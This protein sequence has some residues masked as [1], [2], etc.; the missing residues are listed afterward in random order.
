MKRNKWLYAALLLWAALI[1]LC[2]R[3][4]ETLFDDIVRCAPRGS[5]LAAGVIVALFA[6]KSV[7]VVLYSGVLY[8]ASGVL[9]PLPT[10]LAVSLAGTAVMFLIPYQVGRRSGGE[11][12]EQL[13]EKYP[14]LHA[15]RDLREKNDFL[16]T[17][18]VRSMRLLSYDVTSL[19][20][21]AAGAAFPAY[22]GASLL[23]SLP[24]LVAFTAMGT[25]AGDM[26]SP[27]FWI[28]LGMEACMLAVSVLR[29]RKTAQCGE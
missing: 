23:A 20:L 15:L 14:R 7:S 24:S 9:F 19:Y 2:L 28:A 10:A 16:F 13:M 1:A 27:T 8:A 6:V 29:G 11:A 26:S 21:G 12:V 4:R 17:L 5:W 18:A 25:G 3:F 22:M